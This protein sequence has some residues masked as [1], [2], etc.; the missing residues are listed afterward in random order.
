MGIY[1]EREATITSPDRVVHKIRLCPNPLLLRG[2]VPGTLNWRLFFGN[3]SF[4][5]EMNTTLLTIKTPR[6]D[7]AIALFVKGSDPQA[8]EAMIEK[9]LSIR[10]KTQ[11]MW[12]SEPRFITEDLSE[13][14]ELEAF[15]IEFDEPCT[16]QMKE[17]VW[18]I[19]RG[20]GTG[21][22]RD[23]QLHCFHATLD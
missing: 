16:E 22:S 12:C 8:L 9:V 7:S 15:P 19:S 20:M 21:Q 4:P 10:T 11:R 14:L 18:W 2:V 5:I 3:E 13:L 23:L 6:G 1:S 17:L